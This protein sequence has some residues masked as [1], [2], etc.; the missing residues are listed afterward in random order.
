VGLKL[1]VKVINKEV[2]MVRM[3]RSFIAVAAFAA[4][5]ASPV[6]ADP[7]DHAHGKGKP[8]KVIYSQGHGKHDFDDHHHFA[9]LDQ[10][11]VIIIREKLAPYYHEHCP[12]GLAKKHNG[13]LPPGQAKKYR[14][15]YVL[16]AYVEYWDVPSDVL[17]L[18]P[19]APP[20]ARY[21]W[22]DRD[23]L[24]M[25]EATKKILDATVIFSAL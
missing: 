12:P 20:G 19:A 8:D 25:S 18:L 15:G 2:P 24:L 13:C 4:F 16:P 22:V 10:D 23:I 7:P 9:Q 5:S 21:V 1:S 14:V 6:L 3:C 17:V 11:R